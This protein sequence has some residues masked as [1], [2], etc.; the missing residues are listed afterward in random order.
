MSG[1][2]ARVGVRIP[3]DLAHRFKIALA[4]K[5][6]TAQKVLE[7]AIKDFTDNNSPE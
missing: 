7:E 4:V 1:T 3:E 6:I 2:D 5:R